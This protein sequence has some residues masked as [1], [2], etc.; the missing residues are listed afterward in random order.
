MLPELDDPPQDLELIKSQR[1]IQKKTEGKHQTLLRNIPPC[2]SSVFALFILSHSLLTFFFSFNCIPTNSLY[3]CILYSFYLE[4]ILIS[5]RIFY[6]SLVLLHFAF[7]LIYFHFKFYFSHLYILFLVLALTISSPSILSVSFFFPL[8]SS[9]S[10]SL[11][12]RILIF[13][14]P[15]VWI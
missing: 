7:F 9:Y 5:N 3:F 2:S 12:Y 13:F 8:V 14:P 11:S 6:P 10:F 1:R 4:F 15:F